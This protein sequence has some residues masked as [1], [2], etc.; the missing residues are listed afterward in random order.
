MIEYIRIQTGI[1]DIFNELAGSSEDS[2]VW[3]TIQD[4]LDLQY[5]S[6]KEQ[7]VI[8][9]NLQQNLK[10]LSEDVPRLWVRATPQLPPLFRLRRVPS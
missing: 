8:I 3:Q 5:S 2:D 1:Q 10:S 7:A 4:S 9:C 6:F